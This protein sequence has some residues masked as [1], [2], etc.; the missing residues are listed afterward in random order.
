MVSLHLNRK[1]PPPPLP[2]MPKKKSTAK[3]GEGSDSDDEDETPKARL[4]RLVAEFES[5]E[6]VDSKAS[7]ARRKE[8]TEEMDRILS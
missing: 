7:N 2:P 6:G 5:L 3:R 1:A 8:I 4:K